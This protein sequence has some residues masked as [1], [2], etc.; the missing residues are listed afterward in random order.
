MVWWLLWRVNGRQIEVCFSPDV[1]LC[2]WLGLR[3]QLPLQSLLA[4][5]LSLVLHLSL[6][7]GEVLK[8]QSYMCPLIPLWRIFSFSLS[9]QT[10]SNAFSRSIHTARVCC[11]FL[12][13]R[14][15]SI[16]WARKVTWSSVD[17]YCLNPAC[18]GVL[19]SFFSVP[20]K[21]RV[22]ELFH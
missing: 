13:W 18:L 17:L 1:I 9:F 5:L 2:G 22:D 12:S 21:P 20:R 11:C 7:V 16:F 8:V 15:S 4:A 3:Y 19:I 14:A 6:S 10:L